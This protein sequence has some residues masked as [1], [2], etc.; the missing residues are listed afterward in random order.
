ML[1]TLVLV[2]NLFAAYCAAHAGQRP[3]LDQP[4]AVAVRRRERDQLQRPVPAA[5]LVGQGRAVDSDIAPGVG[6]VLS[7]FLG[8]I[9]HE[10]VIF[11][12]VIARW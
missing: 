5:A 4:A 3:G 11:K 9:K 1:E 7:F 10:F 6:W 8:P 12:M 2:A